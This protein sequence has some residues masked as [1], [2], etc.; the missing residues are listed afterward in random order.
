[1][2]KP[3]KYRFRLPDVSGSDN[4]ARA[5]VRAFS[6]AELQTLL[7]LSEITTWDAWHG[8]NM[9]EDFYSDLRGRMVRVEMDIVDAINNISGGG[10]SDLVD[11][12]SDIA[13]EL[14]LIRTLL[15][16]AA[17]TTW[18]DRIQA[19]QQAIRDE[20][21]DTTGDLVDSTFDLA[22]NVLTQGAI[23][24]VDT[25]IEESA[26]ATM[27]AL[28][29]SV[30]GAG[31]ASVTQAIYDLKRDIEVPTS[32][33]IE[34]VSYQSGY[35]PTTNQQE[36]SKPTG[37]DISYET[38]NESDGDPAVDEQSIAQY[39]TVPIGKIVEVKQRISDTAKTLEQ[40]QTYSDTAIYLA[41]LSIGYTDTSDNQQTVA[42]DVTTSLRDII[43]PS[44]PF[45]SIKS[46]Q[47]TDYYQFIPN[48]LYRTFFPFAPLVS[49]MND[50]LLLS[51]SPA[52]PITVTWS[53]HGRI[54]LAEQKMR[55][56]LVVDDVG[57]THD[58]DVAKGTGRITVR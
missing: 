25:A 11:P 16:D 41:G 18:R 51:V 49:Y 10:T 15:S 26:E 46:I 37:K 42:L 23:E 14:D 48:V 30:M 9:S 34:N 44:H 39:I 13:Q 47:T 38:F 29:M 35:P 4:E 21:I 20:F 5:Y 40:L 1:M 45:P 31:F 56:A 28:L 33:Y 2:A 53:W 27:L 57:V 3:K 7:R 43:F 12:L 19:F 52:Y 17:E 50:T 54:D 24:A 8:E 58:G 32:V 36:Y 6:F 55:R 22:G